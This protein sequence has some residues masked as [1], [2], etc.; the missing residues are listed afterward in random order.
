MSF[1]RRDDGNLAMLAHPP[2][3]SSEAQACLPPLA[4]TPEHFKDLRVQ[5]A[6]FAKCSAGATMHKGA[7][8]VTFKG[9]MATVDWVNRSQVAVRSAYL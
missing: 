9:E 8:G 7:A 1:K 6:G 3:N 5:T 4:H 2:T